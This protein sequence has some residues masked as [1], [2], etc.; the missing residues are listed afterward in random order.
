MMPNMIY[1]PKIHIMTESLDNDIRPNCFH[2]ML[3]DYILLK[4]N[5][6]WL[7]LGKKQNAAQHIS[8]A[9]KLFGEKVW[10]KCIASPW[11]INAWISAI[12]TPVICNIGKK[13]SSTNELICFS[14]RRVTHAAAA[15]AAACRNNLSVPPVSARL[16]ESIWLHRFAQ[17]P[18]TIIFIVLINIT[19]QPILKGGDIPLSAGR[20]L[21]AE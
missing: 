6:E 9:C 7:K 16:F 1:R 21:T 5:A 8:S 3:S 2:Y 17:L 14:H 18:I 4:L 19:I 13:L 20:R 15:A 10:W 11:G 12:F